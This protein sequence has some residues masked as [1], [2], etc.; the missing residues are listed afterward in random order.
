MFHVTV[1]QHVGIVPVSENRP[2]Q[3]S[4]HVGSLMEYVQNT[5]SHVGQNRKKASECT[6]DDGHYTKLSS[7][8]H[9]GVSLVP[10][11]LRVDTLGPSLTL[12]ALTRALKLAYRPWISGDLPM[13][14]HQRD[15]SIR[16]SVYAF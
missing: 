2:C 13:S 4:D 5:T 6:L 14:R 7:Y 15:D 11:L 10:W 9:V 16:I 8:T 12:G 3:T 1:H